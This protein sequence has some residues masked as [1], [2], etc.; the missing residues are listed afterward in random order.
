MKRPKVSTNGLHRSKD[1]GTGASTTFSNIQFYAKSNIFAGEEL[2]VEY[3]DEWFADRIE[4]FGPI[5][6]SDDFQRANLILDSFRQHIGSL[7]SSDSDNG[8]SDTSDPFQTEITKALWSFISED[9]VSNDIKLGMALPK[10]VKLIAER[11]APSAAML[12]LPDAMRDKSWLES[13][14]LCID[15]IRPGKS[16]IKQAGKGAFATRE[17]LK[18][19]VISPA[20]LVH[21]KRSDLH[22]YF[23][24]ES[25]GIEK[26]GE[27]LLLNYCYGHPESSLLF[28]PY[29]PVINFVN[30]NNDSSKINARLQW[31]SFPNHSTEWLERNVAQVLEEDHAGLIM[32]VIATKDIKEGEEIFI[33]Y[34]KDWQDSWDKHLNDWVEGFESNYIPIDQLNASEHILRTLSE[35]HENPYPENVYCACYVQELHIDLEKVNH[36]VEPKNGRE[37]LM[38]FISDAYDCEILSRERDKHTYEYYYNVQVTLPSEKNVLVKGVPRDVIEFVEKEYYSDQHLEGA[39]RHEIQ[40]PDDIFPESWKDLKVRSPGVSDKVPTIYHG[41]D[42]NDFFAHAHPDESEYNNCRLYFAE[43]SIPD[44]GLG[45]YTGVSLENEDL[46]HPDIAIHLIDDNKQKELRCKVDSSKCDD[47]L[48]SAYSWHGYMTHASNDADSVIVIIP[49]AG[50]MLNFQPGMCNTKMTRCTKDGGG[51]HRSTDPGAG[52]IS[53]SNNLRFRTTMDV[54]EG[55][56]LFTDYGD[57]WLKTREHV[58]G[59][60]PLESDYLKADEKI[61]RFLSFSSEH[62][63]SSGLK[64]LL[65]KFIREE[66]IDPGRFQNALPTTYEDIVKA[67]QVGT[68]RQTIPNVKRSLEWLEKNGRCVDYIRQGSSTISSAGRG[69]FARRKIQKGE[70]ITSSPLLHID[71]FHTRLF[72]EMDDGSVVVTGDQL[73]LN[74]CYGHKNSSVLLFPYGPIINSINHNAEDKCNGK[75][76]WSTHKNH[77]SEWLQ[78]SAEE[79]LS[80]K[81]SGL[82]IDVVA[83]KDIENGEEIFINYGKTWQ[84]AWNEH[85][86]QW[87]PT[88]DSKSYVSSWDNF[89]RKNRVKTLEEQIE[90]PYP[91]NLMTICFVFPDIKQFSSEQGEFGLEFPWYHT[92][93]LL[94]YGNKGWPCRI[95]RRMENKYGM[96]TSITYIAAVDL[97]EEIDEVIVRGIPQGYI[98]VVDKPYSN[99]ELMEGTFRH[100]IGIEDIF[101]STWM[102][103]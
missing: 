25:S 63:N 87:K 88:S 56:E 77:K 37:I 60:V 7:N 40:I 94:N 4:S 3:G 62:L 23:E 95:L 42:D 99:D 47:W 69:A 75:I 84:D 76:E 93:D 97:P 71:R 35:Q 16:S 85:V 70:V 14:G 54:S 57:E 58:L 90:K 48:F 38:R 6:L 83:T 82:L 52:A 21:V 67:S 36:W 65:W 61:K 5:P 41:L 34:G 59:L 9:L 19:N 39:F 17:I 72:K 55:M 68:S 12:N 91:E 45:I 32:E 74:Y 53:L 11:T 80:E 98:D 8:K 30:H 103:L 78:K 50:A 1:P 64:D 33:D 18:G 22:M 43:S 79:I 20:P 73:I 89:Q 28:F 44:A 26:I 102:D 15:N 29:A 66:I 49:G 46:L 27:Q 51:L 101:P 10:D 81:Y 13:N 24:S 92:Q 96:E 100:E 2:F 86:Q 31:S